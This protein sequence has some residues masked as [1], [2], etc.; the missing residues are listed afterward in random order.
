MTEEAA[1]TTP[2]VTPQPQNTEAA[3]TPKTEEQKPNQSRTRK[4]R[5]D[6]KPRQEKEFEE[7]ILQIDRVTRVTKGGRQMRFR[8]TVVIGDKNGRVGFGIGKSS[9]VIIGIQKAVSDAKK[10][11]IRVPSF[12]GTLPH[13]AIGRY[14]ASN[15]LLFPA[16]E[17]KGIIAGGAVRKILELAGLRDVLSKVHG[18]R[19]RINIAHATFRAL[20][21]MINRAPKGSEE[22][23][24]EDTKA[25]PSVS[26]A[27]KESDSKI[28]TE[29]TKAPETTQS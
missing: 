11:M 27:K 18:S 3:Q 13:D 21:T 8:I 25:Q 10:N 4:P 6:R 7:A 24:E 12:N 26:N 19:N 2:E 16:P 5:R 15:V 28:D 20:G 1:T 29:N 9:E 22:S 17:G 23:T 14:K